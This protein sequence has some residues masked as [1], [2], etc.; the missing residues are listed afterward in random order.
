MFTFSLFTPLIRF[1]G[2]AILWSMKAQVQLEVMP[3]HLRENS[4]VFD[5]TLN[6]RMQ[7]AVLNTEFSVYN[8]SG[9]YCTL[10]TQCSEQRA[11]CSL[12]TLSH[13]NSDNIAH[14]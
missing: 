3:T 13:D 5:S 9:H 11:V 7:L 14:D 8:A 6:A 4:Q 1:R 2:K 10:K 12:N